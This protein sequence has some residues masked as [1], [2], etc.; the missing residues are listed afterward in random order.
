MNFAFLRGTLSID[1]SF[2][3]GP[4]RDGSVF[5][6]TAS[7]SRRIHSSWGFSR[8]FA[9]P[10]QQKGTYLCTVIELS[11]ILLFFRNARVVVLRSG[12]RE[13]LSTIHTRKG[14]GTTAM[15]ML[16]HLALPNCLLTAIANKVHHPSIS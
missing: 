8:F 11:L 15:G 5:F 10:S 4:F 9:S 6:E 13:V 14:I 16:L 1:I 2:S 3:N 12:Q 7:S